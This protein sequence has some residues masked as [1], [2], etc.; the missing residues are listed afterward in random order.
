MNRTILLVN[1]KLELLS[2]VSAFLEDLGHLVQIADSRKEALAKIRAFDPGLIIASIKLPDGNGFELTEELRTYYQSKAPVILMAPLNRL[3]Q[4]TRKPEARL[5]QAWIKWPV[6]QMELYS[7]IGEW[8][9]KEIAVK[10]MPIRQPNLPEETPRPQPRPK[11]PRLEP[12]KR[13]LPTPKSAPTPLTSRP[14]A[15]PVHAAPK[16]APLRPRATERRAAADDRS[17]E[18]IGNLSRTPLAPLLAQIGQREETGLLTMN[19]S[20]NKMK[21]H[22]EGGAIVNVESN[23]IPDLSLGVVL[24]KRG[25]ITPGELSGARKRWEREG[26]LL[27]Q[28]LISLQ[29]VNQGTLDRALLE[30]RLKKVLSLFTWQW[31]RGTY[32]FLRG[33]EKITRLGGFRLRVEPAIIEGIRACYD[34]ERLSGAF[35]KNQRLNL[36]LT[37]TPVTAEELLGRMEHGE[38]QQV[39]NTLRASRTLNQA[40]SVS[41]LDELSF[42]QYTYAL[43]VL[44]LLRFREY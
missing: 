3:D 22:F 9:G 15:A 11:G 35:N 41:N 16:T 28:T 21:I 13:P 43:Y 29:L 34:M 26:G 33:E 20:P 24:A 2:K 37:L 6:E 18:I 7:A 23:Y 32:T 8:L 19:H 40:L 1:E 38:L 5:V 44:D 42:L 25:D 30:Q 27:G 31:E 10:T 17:D 4:L 36:P 12:P 14:A 39:I